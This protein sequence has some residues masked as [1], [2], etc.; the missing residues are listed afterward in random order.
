MEKD[1]YDFHN[2]YSSPNITRVSKSW[3]MVWAEQAV[4]IG[5]LRNT[6]EV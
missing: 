3:R 2:L 1:I 4:R 6:N 5:R